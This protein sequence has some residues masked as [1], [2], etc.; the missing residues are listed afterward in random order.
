MNITSYL[1][2]NIALSIFRCADS[3]PQAFFYNICIIIDEIELQ[4]FL[5]GLLDWMSRCHFLFLI[6]IPDGGMLWHVI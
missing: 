6:D 4:Y 2:L 3:S 1:Y 5:R